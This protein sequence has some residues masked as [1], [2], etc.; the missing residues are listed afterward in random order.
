[1][2]GACMNRAKKCPVICCLSLWWS[3]PFSLT[4]YVKQ[5]VSF[6]S[7]ILYFCLNFTAEHHTHIL[8]Y[9]TEITPSVNEKISKGTSNLLHIYLFC[10]VELAYAHCNW[11]H[12]MTFCFQLTC[13]IASFGKY[14]K[15]NHKPV[16]SH[17][18]HCRQ[19]KQ[20]EKT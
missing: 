1:M 20:Y 7:W 2:K 14:L 13:L 17:A 8:S 3:F 19:C 16:Q 10:N 18:S 4:C 9:W 5:N 11:M 12:S 6:P 15:H